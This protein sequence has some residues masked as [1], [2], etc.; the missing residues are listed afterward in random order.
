MNGKWRKLNL[1]GLGKENFIGN[2]VLLDTT[3]EGGHLDTLAEAQEK[4]SPIGIAD[5]NARRKS[6]E[7]LGKFR[8]IP[9]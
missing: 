4:R 6:N 3:F 7:G 2:P 5:M 9:L 8:T 1:A